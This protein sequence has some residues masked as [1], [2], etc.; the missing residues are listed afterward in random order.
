MSEQTRTYGDRTGNGRTPGEASPN[1]L[2]ELEEFLR[3]PSISSEGGDPDDLA[4]AAGWVA[5]R[6]REAGGHVDV[7]DLGGNPLVVGELSSARDNAPDVL[8]YGH[9]DVQSPDPVSAWTTP[10]FEPSIREGRLYAR[11]ASDD[12][13]NFLPLLHVACRLAGSRELPVNVRV[14]V[15]GEEEI[16]GDS[17]ARWLAADRR[18]AD[19]AVVF[20]MDM[21]DERTPALT[22]GVRGIISLDVAVRT[23][24]RDVHSGMY[25]GVAL[26]AVHVLHRMLGEVLPG[27]DGRLRP[28]L[29]VGA[30]APAPPE[31]AS[32]ARLPSGE[33]VLAAAGARAV[34]PTAPADLY[35]RIWTDAS[36]DVNGFAGGDALQRR[37]IIPAEARAKVS[38]RLA[39]GQQPDE[40][41]AVLV[42]LLRTAA[43][44]GAEVMIETPAVAAAAMFDPASPALVRA[45]TVLERVCGV[46]PVLRRSGGSIPVLATF[47]ERGI[48]SIVSGFAL[49]TDRIHAPDESFRLESLRLGELAAYELYAALADLRQH[50][51]GAEGP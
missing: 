24:E 23:A 29:R 25:G 27:P 9:Y 15:D 8:I 5:E 21:L 35:E 37:T 31:R 33:D 38:M 47:A 39:A 6:I 17:A 11:G 18:G 51:V 26:N 22:L 32:W 46:A 50:P 49:D 7:L 20:D 10:P 42:G 41:A 48:P 1:L 3:I 40:M 45:A 13:G 14:V 44:P 43:P 36:V 2:A 16:G 19:C 30:A 4:R 34:H 12:K 28:E